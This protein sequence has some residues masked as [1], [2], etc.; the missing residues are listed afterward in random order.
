MSLGRIFNKRF[1]EAVRADG[2][3][4]VEIG[5]AAGYSPGYLWNLTTGVNSNPT[6]VLVEVLGQTLDIDPLWLLGGEGRGP[7]PPSTRD[8]A[9]TL[10]NPRS[11]WKTPERIMTAVR[12]EAGGMT[13]NDI[14]EAMGCTP[15][16]LR[17]ILRHFE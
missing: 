5:K 4:M 17:R 10:V 9:K 12:M 14:C 13:R 1:D 11:F 15:V 8:K 6:L 16:S 7:L 2:R 3:S